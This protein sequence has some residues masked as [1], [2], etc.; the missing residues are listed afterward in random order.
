MSAPL[1]EVTQNLFRAVNEFNLKL[2]ETQPGDQLARLVVEL[3]W[4]KLLDA[5]DA[6][7]RMARTMP[8]SP[9]SNWLRA[10]LKDIDNFRST[11]VEPHGVAG[12]INGIPIDPA[13]RAITALRFPSLY[14]NPPPSED[15]GA[16]FVQGEASLQPATGNAMTALLRVFTNGVA[17]ERLRQA[18]MILAD[19]SLNVNDKLTRIDG[20][21]RFPPTAS[22]EQ[23][24]AMLS[25]SKQAVMKTAWWRGNR[26][27]V[28][29]E[30]VERRRTRLTERGRRYEP[31]RA[32]GDDDER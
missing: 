21:I 15:A 22:A 19:D 8:P 1:H 18:A 30:E 7:R 12:C 28:R 25:V 26:R 31:P 4:V 3:A 14:I 6:S 9:L 23:L 2:Q 20:L 32:E 16:L 24:G 11:Y 13:G 27:G 10:A 29:N 5:V 17:D